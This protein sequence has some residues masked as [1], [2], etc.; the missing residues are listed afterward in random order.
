MSNLSLY[1]KQQKVQ[2]YLQIKIYFDP[3]FFVRSAEWKIVFLGYAIT[4]YAIT[5]LEAARLAWSG[6]HHYVSW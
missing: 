2:Q 6:T 1:I 5:K 3:Q 4:K